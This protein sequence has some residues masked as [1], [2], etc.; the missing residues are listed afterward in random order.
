MMHWIITPLV[1]SQWV[2][3]PLWGAVFSFTQVFFFDN[4][5]GMDDNAINAGLMQKEMNHPTKT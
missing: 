2:T 5:F 4:S 3:N 1:V